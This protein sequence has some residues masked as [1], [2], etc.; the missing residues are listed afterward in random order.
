MAKNKEPLK[1]VK[2]GKIIVKLRCSKG[3]ESLTPVF[4]D[5]HRLLTVNLVDV[6]SKFVEYIKEI[7]DEKEVEAKNN[8]IN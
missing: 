5:G 8:K 1:G 6:T 2:K 3:N 7:K 4:N